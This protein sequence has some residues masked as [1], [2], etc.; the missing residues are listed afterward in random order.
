[1][2]TH[3]P[4]RAA[5]HRLSSAPQLI[6]LFSRQVTSDSFVWTVALQALLSME[7]SRQEYWS[8]LPF[9]VY[10]HTHAHMYVYIHTYT[11][12][13]WIFAYFK[14]GKLEGRQVSYWII[15]YILLY[16]L[17]CWQATVNTLDLGFKLIQNVTVSLWLVTDTHFCRFLFWWSHKISCSL[18]I[19]HKS[20]FYY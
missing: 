9:P 13:L 6:L 19:I 5:S 12:M 11:H 7:F 3:I 1:M 17:N 10:I 16:C 2:Q 15:L 4:A 18:E 14:E 8:G 20:T